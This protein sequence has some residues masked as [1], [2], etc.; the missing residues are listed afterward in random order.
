MSFNNFAGLQFNVHGLE[1]VG[2]LNPTAVWGSLPPADILR[3]LPANPASSPAARCGSLS[4]CPSGV[5]GLG[6]WVIASPGADNRV[7]ITHFI[8]NL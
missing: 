4:G 5:P 1:L 3:H 2:E 8:E 7:S 6:W